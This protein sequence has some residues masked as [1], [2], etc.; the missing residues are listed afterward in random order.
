[1]NLALG[2]IILFLLFIV[3]SLFFHRLYYS[4]E[5]SKQYFKSSPFELFLSA[6][7]PGTLFQLLFY[8]LVTLLTPY[9][10]DFDI[11]GKLLVG[12][13]ENEAVEA[14]SALSNSLRLIV[15]YNITLWVLLAVFGWSA[16]LVVRKL[17]LDRSYGLFRYRNH[18]H[19]LL[20]GEILDFPNIEGKESDIDLTYLNVLVSVGN[21]IYLYSGFLDHFQLTSEG[22]GLDYILLSSV[23]RREVKPDIDPKNA[24]VITFAGDFFLLPY[25][26]I[27]NMNIHFIRIT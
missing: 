6:V 14:F 18:W 11:M 27:L 7:V 1:M 22:S 17:K 24:P 23:E 13:K 15:Y 9:R 20:R 4:G 25:A 16:K 19:Y 21:S 2:A 10:V 8:W 26:S 12:G 3:P 5:F